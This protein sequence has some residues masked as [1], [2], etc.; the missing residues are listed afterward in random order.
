MSDDDT[1]ISARRR[2]L[3]QGA[4]AAVGAVAGTAHAEQ[5]TPPGIPTG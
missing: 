3:V 4:A 1:T 2:F 5:A